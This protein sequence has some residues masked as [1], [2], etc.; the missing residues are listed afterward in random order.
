MFI[1]LLSGDLLSL[2]TQSLDE[3]RQQLSDRLL[4]PRRHFKLIDP[5]TGEEATQGKDVLY[6]LLENQPSGDIVPIEAWWEWSFSDSVYELFEHVGSSFRPIHSPEVF[7]EVVRDKSYRFTEYSPRSRMTVTRNLVGFMICR[8]SPVF[9]ID[10]LPRLQKR[11]YDEERNV[12]N[13]LL[14][15]A[16]ANMMNREY[17]TEEEA[18][19]MLYYVCRTVIPR[20]DLAIGG[21]ETLH[22]AVVR[23]T[24]RTLSYFMER[25][26]VAE[27]VVVRL[28]REVDYMV[29]KGK[30]SKEVRDQI[31]KYFV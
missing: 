9:L 6:L 19:E 31:E 25:E 1:K 10:Y 15:A 23:N 11:H 29:K 24:P 17:Y 12:V 14:C 26:P 20:F 21:M 2:D 8:V 13:K 30:Y 7:E 16:H 18:D 5:D 28:I 3:A 22:N 4:L 27:E